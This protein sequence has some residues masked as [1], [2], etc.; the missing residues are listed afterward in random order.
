MATRHDARRI[1]EL[2][3]SLV[4]G[5]P[6]EG[7]SLI[8]ERLT[9]ETE[10]GRVD[11]IP[12]HDQGILHLESQ[13]ILSALLP[14]DNRLQE[15]LQPI[16]ANEIQ[17]SLN[18]DDFLVLSR[19]LEIKGLTPGGLSDAMASLLDTSSLVRNALLRV[20]ESASAPEGQKRG[21]SWIAA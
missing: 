13:L 21:D 18:P 11:L 9:F 8:T 19:R 1:E 4:G 10:D 17:I 3:T 20:P 2:I 7:E 15:L 5:D 16:V 14:E 6:H 12:D